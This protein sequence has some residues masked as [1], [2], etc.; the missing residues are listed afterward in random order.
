MWKKFYAFQFVLDK[1]TLPNITSDFTHDFNHHYSINILKKKLNNAGVRHISSFPS[2]LIRKIGR[3]LNA[4]PSK[5]NS[6]ER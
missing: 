3:L 5:E 1:I 2:Y 6:L 4:N